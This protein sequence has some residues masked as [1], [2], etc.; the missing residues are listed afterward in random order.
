MVEIA[1][2]IYLAL[3]NHLRQG[4][5]YSFSQLQRIPHYKWQGQTP[6][7]PTIPGKQARLHRSNLI[8]GFFNVSC[9]TK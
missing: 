3:P 6:P 4:D 5:H 9:L 2:L 1:I 8:S 7:P